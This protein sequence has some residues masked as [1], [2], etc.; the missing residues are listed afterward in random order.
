MPNNRIHCAISKKRTGIDF[1][2]LHHWMDEPTERLGYNHRKV[3]HYYNTKDEKAIREFWD[4]KG[5]LGEKAVVEWLFHIALDNIET[6]FKKSQ[7]VYGPDTYNF[8]KLGLC[9][10][11]YIYCDFE[12]MPEEEFKDKFRGDSFYDAEEKEPA[13]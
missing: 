13:D 9:K 6:A 11:D 7:R 3:R 1:Q 2:E 4:Q 10:S 8:L 12:R 5:G